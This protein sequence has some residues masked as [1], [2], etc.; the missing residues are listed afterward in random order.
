[1]RQRIFLQ[2]AEELRSHFVSGGKEE[3][4]EEDIFNDS[5]HA[6]V[7]LPDGD[8]GEQRA[9]GRA[10]AERSDPDTPDEE[11]NRQGQED[12][13]FLM[14]SKRVGQIVHGGAALSSSGC[15]WV[16]LVPIT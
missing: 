16:R 11:A 8:T 7:Q 12:R 2:G 10:K 1:M 5:R 15:R 9:H 3:E 6:D 4:I 13:E 14:L